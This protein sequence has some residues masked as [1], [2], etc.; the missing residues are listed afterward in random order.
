MYT[1]MMCAYLL[2]HAPMR[3]AYLHIC[4]LIRMCIP[5]PEYMCISD[6]STTVS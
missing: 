3:C 5:T 1:P 4:L 2:S 6:Y